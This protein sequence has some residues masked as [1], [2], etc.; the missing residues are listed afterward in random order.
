MN[1]RSTWIRRLAAPSSS[2]S[3]SLAAIALAGGFS[4]L[5]AKPV[6]TAR[7]DVDLVATEYGV[8]DLWG[9][10]LPARAQALIAIAHPDFRERLAAEAAQARRRAEVLRTTAPLSPPVS[11]SSFFPLERWMTVGRQNGP[12]SA[13]K[14]RVCDTYNLRS[15]VA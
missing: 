5:G 9:L 10:D 4:E 12:I 14:C 11:S 2:A 6:T 15:P 8:A 13:C 7:S 1:A 3:R